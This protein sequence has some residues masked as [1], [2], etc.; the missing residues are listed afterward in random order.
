MIEYIWQQSTS[1]NKYSIYARMHLVQVHW[2]ESET[3]SVTVNGETRNET[4]PIKPH[5]RIVKR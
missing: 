1:E 3:R 4:V 5:Q 2:D